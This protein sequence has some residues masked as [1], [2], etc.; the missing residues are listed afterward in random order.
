MRT[1]ECVKQE[2]ESYLLKIVT[3]KGTKVVANGLSYIKANVMANKLAREFG[4]VVVG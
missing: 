3:E 2:K 4:L 1:I